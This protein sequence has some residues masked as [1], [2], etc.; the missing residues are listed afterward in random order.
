MCAHALSE[1]MQYKPIAQKMMEDTKQM[2]T[3]KEVIRLCLNKSDDWA[4]DN[5]VN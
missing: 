4:R 2:R 3:M 5:Q 1:I